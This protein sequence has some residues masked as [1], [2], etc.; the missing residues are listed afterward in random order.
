[1]HKF[2]ENKFKEPGKLQV[3]LGGFL[4]KKGMLGRGCIERTS[5]ARA[6]E[7]FNRWKTIIEA[8]YPCLDSNTYQISFFRSGSPPLTLSMGT[9]FPPVE[10]L[11]SIGNKSNSEEVEIFIYCKPSKDGLLFSSRTRAF[12]M[13]Y[14][15]T[16]T[17]KE[18]SNVFL[19]LIPLPE[20]QSPLMDEIV[21]CANRNHGFEK[22]IS[23]LY[24]PYRGLF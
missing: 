1:M 18:T 5:T 20:K 16:N 11:L 22:K 7:D 23:R 21:Q 14:D 15:F 3:A 6:L 13:G 17:R 8:N 2:N 10:K 12:N 9:Y 4:A 19:F 24:P